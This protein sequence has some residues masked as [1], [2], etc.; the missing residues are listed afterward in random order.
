MSRKKIPSI[1]IPRLSFYY[2]ALLES[3]GSDFISS[4]E[5]AKLT[6]FN[7]A[8]IRKD[9]TY[10]G[11]FGIPSKGYK[12]EDL[13]QK[14]LNILGTDRKWN[15][16]LVGVGNLGSALLSYRGFAKQGFE[17]ISAFDNDL[18]KIGK[19]LEGVEVQDISELSQTVKEKNIQIGIVAVPAIAA[20]EVINTLIKAGVRAILNFAPIRPQVSNKVE[21]L[22]IDLSI[23]VERLAFFLRRGR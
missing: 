1:V 23:E 11:Q 9:L 16:G 13:K 7:A 22:N 8:Q 21:L 14:I 2:R 5:L 18:R 15:V 19:K 6:G 4:E 3:R 17:I 12:I 20:Q 10:F